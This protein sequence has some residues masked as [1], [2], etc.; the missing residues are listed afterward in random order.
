L[1]YQTATGAPVAIR[2]RSIVTKRTRTEISLE[3]EEQVALR[4]HRI[5][6]ADCP[7]CRCEVPMIPANEA[8]MIASVKARKIYEFVNSGELHFTEDR[9]GLLYVCSESLRALPSNPKAK[10]LTHRVNNSLNEEQTNHD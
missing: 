2:N 7:V 6:V 4:A 9:F 10:L 8:A 3:I 1:N 5:S